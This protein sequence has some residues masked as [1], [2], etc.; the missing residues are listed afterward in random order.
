MTENS[1]ST[2]KLQLELADKSPR[3]IL[4]RAFEEFDNIAL[5]FSGAEDVVLIDMALNIKKRYSS[6][7]TGHWPS[8]PRNL[9][10]YR[11]GP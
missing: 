8:T 9:S 11:A 6:I 3:A 1:L 4:K 10:V 7:F 5:S 2:S